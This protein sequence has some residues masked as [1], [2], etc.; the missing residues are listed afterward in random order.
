[1]RGFRSTDRPIFLSM[2]GR[3]IPLAIIA[4][5][6]CLF[7]SVA[8]SDFSPDDGRSDMIL[9][10]D[11]GRG[12]DMVVSP[13]TSTED[14]IWALGNAQFPSQRRYAAEILG[15]RNATEAVPGLLDALKDPEDVVQNDAAEAL[16]SIGDEA[17]IEQ[18]IEN[19]KEPRACVRRYS[20]YVLGQFAKKQDDTR[21]CHDI[22]DALLTLTKDEDDL[23]RRDV[24]YALFEIG[25]P[26]SK[27]VFIEGLKDEDPTVRRYSAGALGKMKGRD[28]ED[29]LTEAFKCEADEN[30][31]RSIA[32][33]LTDLGTRAALIVIIENLPNEAEV[34]RMDFAKK[35]A[36][37]DS[38]VAITTLSKLVI[39]DWSPRVRA[40]AAASLLE[41]KDPSTLPVL[42]KALKD[43]VVTVRIPAS[44]ALI[45]L[46]DESAAGDL[47]EALGD[48]SPIVADNA[49][50][51]LV[52]MGSLDL[53]PGLIE[54]LDDPRP[55]AV[56]RAIA[57]LQELTYKPFGSNAQAWKT[58]F[59]ESFKTDE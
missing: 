18:L 53:V 28:A 40:N 58:W 33:A 25:A 23:V 12:A 39:E 48:S 54:M 27:S 29:A 59:E 47:L 46:A 49:A 30:T 9:A 37:V 50:K 7:S 15:K 22:V 24:V 36:G 26:S 55:A 57:V 13:R 52:R 16:A 21:N 17:I 11:A 44:A 1:M 2:I 4:S 56:D 38:P 10:K 14:L 43:R 35:L 20:A 5:L 19:L 8:A 42:K 6:V 34:V 41:T 51:A 3:V 45:E 32:A 31:R